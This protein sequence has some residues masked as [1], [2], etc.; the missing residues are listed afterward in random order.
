MLCFNVYSS[1]S[2]FSTFN[3]AILSHE[4]TT[5]KSS[6]ILLSLPIDQLSSAASISILI[7]GL[8]SNEFCFQKKGSSCILIIIYIFIKVYII[9]HCHQTTN[10]FYYQQ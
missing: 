10:V 7:F 9:F 8:F 6:T 4:Y 5:E 2:L 1:N 3:T